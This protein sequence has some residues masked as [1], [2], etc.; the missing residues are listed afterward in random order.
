MRATR[1]SLLVAA[2]I[3]LMLVELFE[4]GHEGN[5][6]TG[7]DDRVPCRRSRPR[8]A[9]IPISFRIKSRSTS[10]SAAARANDWQMQVTKVTRPLVDSGL[11]ALP[12]GQ[13]YVGV[14]IT[15]INGGG[16]AVTVDAH[17]LFSL[18]D[19]K[20]QGHAVVDGANGA[21]G[22]D[23]PLEPGATLE[24][25]FVFAAPAGLDLLMGLDGA[26]IN[27][28]RTVFQIDP[29]NHPEVD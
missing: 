15:L 23:A 29:P 5:A 2:C 4:L 22:F 19:E 24:G 6:R 26:E 11:P 16:D 20:G 25:H 3:T 27:T 12:A 14:D 13:Q 8:P 7:I 9:A 28:Q 17:K 18:V 10:A 21:S 1:T